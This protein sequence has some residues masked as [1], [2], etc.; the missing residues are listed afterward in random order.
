M[1]EALR[2][3]CAERGRN[4]RWEWAP[5]RVPPSQPVQC[6]GHI[7]GRV[8]FASQKLITAQGLSQ[9]CV[10]V[11]PML[12][13]FILSIPSA[14]YIYWCRCGLGNEAVADHALSLSTSAVLYSHTLD[15]LASRTDWCHLYL[16]LS[17]FGL[18]WLLSCVRYCL[19][20]CKLASAKTVQGSR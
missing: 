4:K 11:L 19:A 14:I 20:E 13:C 10:T 3:F 17:T 7:N 9:D 8:L 16:P 5:P 18:C 1:Y 6:C 2:T 12:T 15:L